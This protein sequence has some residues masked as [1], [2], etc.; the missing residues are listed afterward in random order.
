[1]P[2]FDKCLIQGRVKLRGLFTKRGIYFMKFLTMLLTMFVSAY[3]FA[4]TVP[5]YRDLKPASQAMLENQRVAAP[6][7]ADT[8]R[9]LTT[10]AGPTSAAVKAVTSFTAQPDVPRNLTITPTGTTADVEAC[11]VTVTGTNFFGRANT[12]VFAFLANAS[13]ATVG[14]E[15]FKTVSSISWAADCESGGF[16]ATWIVGVGDVLGLKRCMRQAGDVA[17]AVFDGVFESTRP[18]CVADA[19]EVEKNT[20]DINGTLNGAKN[21]DLFFVQ[22]YACLP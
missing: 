22:N 8:D 20:C 14:V 17:W 12:E 2:A 15:A 9:V 18:T 6:V 19:D 3:A 4:Y 16:E 5:V 21:V 10:N 1:L 13:T 11:N 7:L